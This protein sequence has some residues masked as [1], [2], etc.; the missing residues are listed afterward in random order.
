MLKL[1]LR[2][3]TQVPGGSLS[4]LTIYNGEGEPVSLAEGF[5]LFQEESEPD[6]AVEMLDEYDEGR[7]L[8]FE[9]A[10]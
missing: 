4:A 9:V 1:K 3:N 5:R 6:L 10:W 2:I 8:S 7:E